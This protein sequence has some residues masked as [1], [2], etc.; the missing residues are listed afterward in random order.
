[1]DGGTPKERTYFS[2]T[3]FSNL[4][5]SVYMTKIISK[6][7]SFT[8]F[9]LSTLCYS[10]FAEACVR[11]LQINLRSM[12]PKANTLR[13]RLSH[14]VLVS[15]LEGTPLGPCDQICSPSMG[16]YIHSHR[17]AFSRTEGQGSAST[18]FWS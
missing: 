16:H 6:P 17:S 2:S 8:C 9:F 7:K 10:L 12:I 5:S 1:V 14:S 3:Y 13:L 15:S 4:N 18:V 11:I